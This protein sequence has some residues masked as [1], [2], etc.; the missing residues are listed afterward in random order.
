MKEKI[1]SV[2]II[3]ML[4]L[5]SML[6]MTSIIRPS[7][8]EDGENTTLNKA[9]KQ[10]QSNDLNSGCQNTFESKTD[11]KQDKISES[12]SQASRNS[13]DKW[14]F[15]DTR[16]WSSLAYVDGNKTRLIVGVNGES[17]ISLLE[18][19]KIA[20]KHQAKIVSTVSIGGEVKAVVV[21]LL[22][23]SV[24]AFVQEVRVAG[25]AS[26]IEPNMK[27]QA[28]FVP[29]DPYWSL[30]WGPQKIEA[31]WAWNTTVG[32]P[33]VLVAVVDTGIYYTHPDIAANYVP[34]GYDWVNN[35]T[36][37]MDDHGHGTHC[38]GIIAATL[39]NSVGIAGLAQ[40]RVMAEKGLSAGGSG[41]E[42]W[43]ANAII[44]AVD[45]GADIISMSWGGY[46]HSELIY[47]AITYACD[48]GVL[49]IAA[50]GND[51]TSIKSYPA[52]YE[53]VVAVAATDRYDNTAVW[54]NFGDWIELAAP[55]VD[56]YSTVPWGYEAWSG[57]S[58]A[59]PHV[60]GV[61]ALLWS[62]YPNKTRDWVRL[63][64]RYTSDDLGD[65]G[66]E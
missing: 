15:N 41:Y 51:A 63:W 53:E 10:D 27:F 20:T 17:S 56:I 4:I 7:F 14:N 38:A 23:A 55:G 16:E 60:A 6:G 65:L 25:L 62:L 48:A 40:V 54:S 59:C 37:P 26:Y 64:L 1:V 34:L 43:L 9:T 12:S 50:A 36:D 42:D 13:G 21:E 31:D 18:L 57:T 35:D 45:Q 49:L 66:F 32:N 19:E 33:S 47:E 3:L 30:Q 2:L 58:M 44:H 61:A 22:F 28:Q 29:N 11:A 39:N 24:T 52:A 46:F 8:A 5:T